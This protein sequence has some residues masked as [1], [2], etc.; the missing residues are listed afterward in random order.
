MINIAV[1]NSASTPLPFALLDQVSAMQTF[2]DQYFTP[3]WGVSAKLAVSTGPIKGSWGMVFLDT[4]D[5]PGDLAYHDEENNEPL[6]KVF[7]KTTLAAGQD[8]SVSA[9]HELV[10]MLVD[11]AC[12]RYAIE[13]DNATLMS[14]EVADPVEDQFQAVNGFNMTNFVYPAWFEPQPFGEQTQ[15]DWLGKLTKPFELSAGGYAVVCANGNWQQ[16][17][18]SS[19]KAEAFPTQDRRGRRGWMRANRA[20]LSIV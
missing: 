18:G 6:A 20:G 2:L 9:S 12:N 8:L 5:E 15:F 14:L 3:I 4:A 10:E 17:F 19:Q 1:Y 11:A 7:V 16:V 13:G